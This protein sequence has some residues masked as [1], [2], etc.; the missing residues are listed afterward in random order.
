MHFI[1]FIALLA[2]F[3]LAYPNSD[4]DLQLQRRQQYS[5]ASNA[6][7]Y[8]YERLVRRNYPSSGI[9]TAY[10]AVRYPSNNYNRNN[11]HHK[12]QHYNRYNGYGG[13]QLVRRGGPPPRPEVPTYYAGTMSAAS[14]L[15]RRDYP[16][17]GI[18]TAYSATRYTSNNYSYNGNTYKSRRPHSGI[19]TAY[20][21]VRYP[22]N[23]YN[24][25]NRN[26]NKQFRYNYNSYGRYR[27]TRRQCS[28][29]KDAYGNVHESGCNDAPTCT[30]D[31]SG[32]LI[33]C[34]D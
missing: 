30:Y 15:V 18:G 22:S 13:Y 25:R 2:P 21:A 6:D 16:S 31:N 28:A 17:S 33:G 11:R 29:Y 8:T 5:P 7:I 1:Q 4:S 3:A 9:G 20:S 26:R 19:G 32:N 14:P 24:N 23:N 34:V 27:L 10:S 12:K